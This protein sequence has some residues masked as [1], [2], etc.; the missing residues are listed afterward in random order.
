MSHFA[1]VWLTFLV[2][3]GFIAWSCHKSLPLSLPPLLLL[4][5]VSLCVAAL[6]AGWVG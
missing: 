2:G 6:G 5:G 4:L 1:D 3:F